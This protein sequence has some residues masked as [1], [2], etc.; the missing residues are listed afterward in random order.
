MQSMATTSTTP[1]TPIHTNEINLNTQFQSFITI[2][3]NVHPMNSKF[4]LY[5]PRPQ[6]IWD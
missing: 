5:S 6:L 2:Q 3:Y 1:T 4:D